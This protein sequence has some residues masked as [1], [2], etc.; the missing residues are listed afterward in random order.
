MVHLLTVTTPSTHLTEAKQKRA[1]VVTA[2]V[3]PGE[4]NSSYMMRGFINFITGL[5]LLLFLLSSCLSLNGVRKVKVQ[6]SS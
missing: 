4:T 5:L 6:T 2:R 1:V 3:H